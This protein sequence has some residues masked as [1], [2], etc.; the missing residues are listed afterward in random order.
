MRSVSRVLTAFV[1]MAVLVP[2][3]PAASAVTTTKLAAMPAGADVERAVIGPSDAY[4]LYLAKGA[5]AE[6]EEAWTVKLEEGAQPMLVSE[7]ADGVP[8]RVNT[9]GFS[10]DGQYVFFTG[11]RYEDGPVD[12]ALWRT[13]V[14][15]SA[16]PTRMSSTG[17]FS[18]VDGWLQTPDGST[19]VLLSSGIWTV[20]T[21][22]SAADATEIA[23]GSY[24]FGVSN[25]DVIYGTSGFDNEFVYRIPITGAGAPV[26]LSNPGVAATWDVIITP[27]SANAVFTEDVDGDGL[28]E[29]FSVPTDGTAAEIVQLNVPLGVD[30]GVRDVA[31]SGDGSRVLYRLGT[32]DLGDP[33]PLYSVPVRGPAASSVQLNGALGGDSVVEEDTFATTPDGSRTVFVARDDYDGPQKVVSVPTAGPATE[34]IEV[35]RPH[36]AYEKLFPRISPTGDRVA[37]TV[38]WE[39]TWEWV[40]VISAPLLASSE[41]VV[42]V[43]DNTDWG[44]TPD[45]AD[46][47]YAKDGLLYRVPATG[48]MDARVPLSEG[49]S[50]AGWTA[51]SD[52]E[53]VVYIADQDTAGVYELYAAGTLPPA[54]PGPT[55]GDVTRLSGADRFATAAAISAATFAPG[56]PAVTIAVGTNF[57]DALAG[58]P[59][60]ATKGGPILLTAT[61]LVPQAT[62]DE[63][64]RLQPKSIDLLG[65]TAVVSPAVEAQLAGYT[66]GAVTRL[67][68]ADRFG[69]AAA[70]SAATYA[71]GVPAAVVAV[72]TNFPDALAG[73]PAAAVLGGPILLTTTDA[74]PQST[75]DELS[76]LQPGS[77]VILG[78]TAVVSPAVEAALADYTTGPVTRLSGGDRFATAAAISAAT[79]DP[80]AGAAMIAVG[81][82]F[83][84]ALAGGPAAATSG[85]PILLTA[86]DA[87]PGPTDGE[88]IRLAPG[89]IVVLG[90]TAVIS[91]QV[92]TLLAD[93]LG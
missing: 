22:G 68:G 44:F 58:G 85:G 18:G 65:G 57:P 9:A 24:L 16:P 77:I 92:E 11:A 35:S 37:Y 83:P 51:T 78:G 89:S 45:G 6:V 30:Q 91:T 40:A 15:G 61:D 52:G 27:D 21:T 14:N 3:V 31:V 46:V 72:G 88:L 59:A 17:G 54:G 38:I 41:S 50:V 36:V 43:G 48:P 84:D 39:P 79:F 7:A 74:V 62:L 12:S 5:S 10:D 13:P 25:T 47:L 55:P 86:T 34:A 82:N 70:I 71:P 1:L 73:G 20:P 19:V 60:A 93:Y 90:G 67:S 63:L 81:T 69:T 87:I 23:D 66:T 56:V 42:L 32:S 28:D 75:A 76:R 49:G 2:S 80:G 29:L 64:T 26:L 33:G 8:I 4:V 53:I